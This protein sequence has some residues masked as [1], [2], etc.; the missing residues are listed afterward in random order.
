MSSV[1]SSLDDSLL[2]LSNTCII[3]INDSWIICLFKIDLGCDGS[4]ILTKNIHNWLHEEQVFWMIRRCS[5]LCMLQF[6]NHEI[7]VFS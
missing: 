3:F 4:L 2:H 1:L 6:E 7:V 5:N